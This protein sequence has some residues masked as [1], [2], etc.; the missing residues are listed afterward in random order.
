MNDVGDARQIYS[1][2]SRRS[3]LLWMS[4]QG[5]NFQAKGPH[6]DN[7]L[8]S[9]IISSAEGAKHKGIV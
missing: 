3:K 8:K 1:V 4:G 7:T 6:R 2:G 9:C 5:W